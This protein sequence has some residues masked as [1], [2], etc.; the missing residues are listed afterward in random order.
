MLQIIKGALDMERKHACDAMQPLDCVF[1]LPMSGVLDDETINSI[2]E[3]GHSRVPLYEHEPKDA[4][5]S[6]HSLECTKQT[7][8][9]PALV[10]PPHA[11]SHCH[12][13]QHN[14][15]DATHATY[16]TLHD[17]D[18]HYAQQQYLHRTAP[19][20]TTPH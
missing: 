4:H 6:Y 3:S 5:V 8:S 15:M 18:Q 14:C 1:M 19:H 9:A 17:W 13:I 12:T 10:T 16:L 20:R 11:M 7:H 2:I